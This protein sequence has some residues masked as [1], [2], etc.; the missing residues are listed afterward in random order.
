MKDMLVLGSFGKLKLEILKT[1]LFSE[2][3]WKMRQEEKKKRKEC[4]GEKGSMM[5]GFQTANEVRCFLCAVS[6]NK[7]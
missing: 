7:V 6:G 2:S 5:E 4:S 1:G 3:G